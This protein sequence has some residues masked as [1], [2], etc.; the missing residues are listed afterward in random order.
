L[1]SASAADGTFPPWQKFPAAKYAGKI[2]LAILSEIVDDG[3]LKLVRR[4]TIEGVPTFQ[5]ANTY[6]PGGLSD[7][8]TTDEHLDRSERSSSPQG[9]GFVLKNP[10]HDGADCNPRDNDLLLRTGA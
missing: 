7:R 4:E 6:H 10:I 8:T 2:P 9:P 5:Y 1:P 3:A